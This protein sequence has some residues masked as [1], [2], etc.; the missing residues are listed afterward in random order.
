[1]DELPEF[2]RNVLESLRQPLEDGIVT[3]SRASGSLTLP[4]KFMLVAAMNPCPCGNMGDPKA[5]CTC[6]ATAINQYS[7]RISGP[8]LDR[9]DI[10]VLVSRESVPSDVRSPGDI[11]A[12]RQHIVGARALQTE[13]LSSAKLV[14]NSD[15]THKDIDRFCVLQPAAERLLTAVVNSKHLSMRAFHKI[16]KIGRTIADLDG[17]GDIAEHHIAEAFALRVN[18]RV[19]SA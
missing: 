4:A 6:S 10:H 9:I 3:I 2:P 15:I 13:R 14:T 5:I 16:K 17:S 12:I 1:M 18:D 7:R 19:T 11:G 8:L